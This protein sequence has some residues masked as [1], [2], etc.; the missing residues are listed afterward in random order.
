MLGE[1]EYGIMVTSVGRNG[2][3]LIRTGS[4]PLEEYNAS[5]PHCNRSFRAVTKK[6][7][8]HEAK[9]ARYVRWLIRIAHT[10]DLQ[11]L[12]RTGLPR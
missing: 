7:A 3:Y 12:W 9:V 11:R 2:Q 4:V 6:R 8:D 5:P 1:E 10:G